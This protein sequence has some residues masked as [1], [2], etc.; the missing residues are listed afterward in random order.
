MHDS[1]IVVKHVSYWLGILIDPALRFELYVSPH[2]AVCACVKV[3][4]YEPTL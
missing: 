2:F 4:W 3:V 1:L